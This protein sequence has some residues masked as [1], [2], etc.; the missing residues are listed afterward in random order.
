MKVVNFLCIFYCLFTSASHAAPLMDLKQ[1]EANAKEFLTREIQKTLS[2]A[3]DTTIDIAIRPLDP[4]LRLAACDNHLTFE[5]NKTPVQSKMSFRARCNGEKPWATFLMAS[6]SLK[7]AIVVIK[8]ELP[9]LHVLE[10]DDLTHIVKDIASLRRGYNTDMDSLV[11]MQLKRNA[12]ANTVLYDFQLQLPDIIKKGDLIT[13][14]TRRGGLT[15]SAPGI[16][17]SDGHRGEKI[18]VENPR[19]SRVIQGRVTGPGSVEVL[20]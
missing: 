16:A 11:G 5:R 9:R 2:D 14:S 18:K 20:L 6:V 4:R 15:V 7:Q 3:T 19:S 8:H 17:M 10:K 12:K 1:L 13:V